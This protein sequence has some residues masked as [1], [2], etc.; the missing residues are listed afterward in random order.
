MEGGYLHNVGAGGGKGAPSRAGLGPSSQA[1][2]EVEE[3]LLPVMSIMC[4]VPARKIARIY[5]TD[6]YLY[7][8]FLFA[9]GYV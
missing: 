9:G 8:T 6:H 4:Q 7:L 2:N 5:N 1:L 3:R